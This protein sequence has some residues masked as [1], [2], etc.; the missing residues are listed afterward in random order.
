MESD[1]LQV[2]T[3]AQVDRRDNVLQGR[4]D[5]ACIVDLVGGGSGSSHAADLVG[6]SVLLGRRRSQ[7]STRGARVAEAAGSDELDPR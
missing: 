2:E 4:Q 6:L 3:S 1:G 5:A 7:L